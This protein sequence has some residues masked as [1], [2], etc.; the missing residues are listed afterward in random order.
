MEEGGY[1]SLGP[2]R[3][4]RLRCGLLGY[5]LFLTLRILDQVLDDGIHRNTCLWLDSS[6]LRIVQLFFL[7]MHSTISSMVHP[8][9]SL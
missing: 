7:P 2:F 3:P 5:D 9:N 6:K 1:S 8:Y 4:C